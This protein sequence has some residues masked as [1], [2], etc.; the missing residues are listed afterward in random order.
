MLYKTAN[1]VNFVYFEKT[2]LSVVRF[3]FSCYRI[4]SIGQLN[5]YYTPKVNETVYIPVLGDVTFNSR[6]CPGSPP[7][8]LKHGSA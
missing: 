6:L 2:Q 5:Q 7:R 4:S 3:Y 8:I 1:V